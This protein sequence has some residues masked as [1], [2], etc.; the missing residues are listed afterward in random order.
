MI[1]TT[2]EE[3]AVEVIVALLVVAVVVA[4]TVGSMRVK[5]RLP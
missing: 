2:P 4:G 5:M 3:M 1:V